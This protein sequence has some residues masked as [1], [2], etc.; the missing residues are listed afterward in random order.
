[1]KRF[2][3]SK[4]K[5]LS[6]ENAEYL[7]QEVQRMEETQMFYPSDFV[8]ALRELAEVIIWS[9]KNVESVFDFFLERNMMATLERIVTNADFPSVVKG[10]GIQCITMLLQNL[11]RKSSVYCICS[12]NHLNRIISISMDESDDELLSIYVSFLKT[13]ALRLNEDTVQ[14]FFESETGNFP[15][16]DRAAK[17]LDA[18]DRIV[19]AAARQIVISVAQ[20]SEPA[21]SVFLKSALGEVFRLM[22]VFLWSQI[23]TL[24]DAVL[25]YAA[26]HSDNVPSAPLLGVASLSDRLEDVVDDLFYINDLF[27][28]P[29]N[30]APPMLENV[31]DEVVLSPLVESINEPF[32]LNPSNSCSSSLVP[33]PTAMCVL[34]RWLLINEIDRLQGLFRKR[35]L[36]SDPDDGGPVFRVFKSGCMQSISGGILLLG[37]MVSTGFF[38]EKKG[39]GNASTTTTTTTTTTT[40]STTRTTVDIISE[41]VGAATRN[42]LAPLGQEELLLM[43]VILE[44]WDIKGCVMDSFPPLQPWE[45]PSCET[46]VNRMCQDLKDLKIRRWGECL[47]MAF[48]HL[49]TRG[50]FTRLSVFEFSLSL[51]MDFIKHIERKNTILGGLLFLSLTVI[52]RRTIAYADYFALR[53]DGTDSNDTVAALSSHEYLRSAYATLFLKLEHVCCGYDGTAGRGGGGG[54]GGLE[55]SGE[56]DLETLSREAS[57]LLPLLPGEVPH[58]NLSSNLNSDV[59]DRRYVDHQQRLAAM[60]PAAHRAAHDRAEVERSELLMWMALRRCVFCEFK[61]PDGLLLSLKE[62]GVRHRP[63]SSVRVSLTA[64]LCFRCELV[65]ERYILQGSPPTAAAGTPMY[66]VL[67]ETEALF[68]AAADNNKAAVVDPTP[69]LRVMFAFQLIY[70]RAVV[71][72]TPFSVIVTHGH[73]SVPL[74]LHVVFRNRWAAQSAVEAMMD[75]AAACRARGATVSYR[76]LNPKSC[77]KPT[78]EED[79]VVDASLSSSV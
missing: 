69:A 37:A 15:L 19:R 22:A 71:S 30:F 41:E 51:L 49:I 67:Y 10:Q 63:G 61:L 55:W 68:L 54:G 45:T 29:H 75:L 34:T 74:Q 1:M 42:E 32:E 62:Y 20:L 76:A 5:K 72:Q 58:V 78:A 70:V 52:R 50:A 24:G 4:S 2:K 53:K 23:K 3:G 18:S 17:L 47:L 65:K 66:L 64:R 38:L 25:E 7:C 57:L 56:C 13:L 40:N 21:I 9:D 16:F 48:Y 79:S 8:E 26:L 36:F 59:D 31:L 77:R 43:D 73:P 44:K 27:A 11:T 39:T 12:N 33:A 28:V 6:L 35:L 46:F 14:F 60:V